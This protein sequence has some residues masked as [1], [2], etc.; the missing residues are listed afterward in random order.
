MLTT[1]YIVSSVLHYIF[2]DKHIFD[3]GKKLV[4]EKQ[5]EK[6][7]IW[8]FKVGHFMDIANLAACVVILFLKCVGLIPW[9]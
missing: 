6:E 5:L 8:L 3:M 2:F 1:I 9:W 4:K 7:Q